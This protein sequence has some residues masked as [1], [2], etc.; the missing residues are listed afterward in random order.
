[1]RGRAWIG[2]LVVVA[3]L[4]SP[5][6]AAAGAPDRCEGYATLQ[7]ARGQV[8]YIQSDVDRG[9]FQY[10]YYYVDAEAG[11]WLESNGTP[12]LQC[13]IW[14]YTSSADTEIAYEA[15][16]VPNWCP[17]GVGYFWDFWVNDVLAGMCWQLS[18]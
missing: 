13:P 12:G 9:W 6:V 15:V 7:G 17:T 4:L 3:G 5:E 16:L 10:G 14:P 1:M 2:G 18:S 11:A 8:F